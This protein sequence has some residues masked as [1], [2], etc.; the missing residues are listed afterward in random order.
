MD[1]PSF[2]AAGISVEFMEYNYPSY[3]QVWG[4]FV[5]DVSVLDLLLNVG[6]DAPRY[7]WGTGK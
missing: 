7:I 6:A 2:V 5:G 3:P 4:E 1:L